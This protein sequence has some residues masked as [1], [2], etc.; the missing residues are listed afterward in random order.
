M[1]Q[2]QQINPNQPSEIQAILK[3]DDSQLKDLSQLRKEIA[4]NS[5]EVNE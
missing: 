5:K 4:G 2:V 3:L 1:D